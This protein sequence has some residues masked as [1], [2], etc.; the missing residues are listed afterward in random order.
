MVKLALLTKQTK[1][2]VVSNNLKFLIKF[3]FNLIKMNLFYLLADVE[4]PEFPVT[5]ALHAQ[6]TNVQ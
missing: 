4:S 1:I 3:Y 5:H 2:Q 6:K